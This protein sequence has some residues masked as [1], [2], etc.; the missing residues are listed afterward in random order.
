L[1][2]LWKIFLKGEKGS[3]LPLFYYKEN[4]YCGKKLFMRILYIRKN[5]ETKW[6]I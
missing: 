4:I 1:L 3:N 5:E 2:K 6:I